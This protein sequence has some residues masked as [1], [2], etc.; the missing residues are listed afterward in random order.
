M[1]D[2]LGIDPNT[3]TVVPFHFKLIPHGQADDYARVIWA[4]TYVKSQKHFEM[5]VPT[6]VGDHVH[7]EGGKKVTKNGNI[8]KIQPGQAIVLGNTAHYRTNI[9]LSIWKVQVRE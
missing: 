1:A 9:G 8:Y 7:Y 4:L 3:I 2:H 6:V 5:Y